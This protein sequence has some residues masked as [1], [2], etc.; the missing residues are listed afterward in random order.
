MR[1]H[2]KL[3][4]AQSTA[5]IGSDIGS[6]RLLLLGMGAYRNWRER[7]ALYGCALPWFAPSFGCDHH[8]PVQTL[9]VSSVNAHALTSP[10]I[11]GPHPAFIH[12]GQ[13]RR[14]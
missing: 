10:V 1:Y 6:H 11:A 12:V 5:E 3:A 8:G 9:L 13:K 7:L 14:Y 2:R 4:S